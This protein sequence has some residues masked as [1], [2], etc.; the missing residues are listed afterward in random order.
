MT[1]LEYSLTVDST[2]IEK[3]LITKNSA[4]KSTDENPRQRKVA[5]LRSKASENKRGFPLQK[6]ANRDRCISIS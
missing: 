2:Y 3:E 6:S 1:F 4:P 5:S